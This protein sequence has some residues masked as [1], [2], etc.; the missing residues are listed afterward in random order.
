MNAKNE[1]CPPPPNSYA[2]ALSHSVTAFG[3][4]VCGNW[5]GLD[6][7]IRVGPCNGLSAP[8]TRV[9]SSIPDTVQ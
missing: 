8:T 3:D 5:V 7:V 4:G 6:A 2:E 1:L 9:R